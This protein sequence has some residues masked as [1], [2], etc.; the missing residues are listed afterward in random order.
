MPQ[1][2][3]ARAQSNEDRRPD[4]EPGW[5]LG[6]S[7]GWYWQTDP[8]LRLT[9]VFGAPTGHGPLGRRPWELPG[10]DTH[11]ADWARQF[12]ALMV[13]RSFENVLWRR[14]DSSGRLRQYLVSGE[15]MFGPK[16]RFRGF[17]GIG[18]EISEALS[19]LREVAL[20]LGD[21]AGTL[22][23]QAAR[24]R[25]LALGAPAAS[26]LHVVLADMEQAAQRAVAACKRLDAPLGRG[27]GFAA[28]SPSGTM[29]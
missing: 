16:G 7:A 1:D 6:G 2:E 13:R 23:S 29:G 12:D 11:H 26:P 18:H 15:P 19:G 4:D 27:E 10:V 20:Q 9:H 8:R 22:A 3:R 24:A 17:R 14:T 25:E 28:L 21:L 5:T